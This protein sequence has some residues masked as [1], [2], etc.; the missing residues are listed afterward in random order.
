MARAFPTAASLRKKAAMTTLAY[1]VMGL[2]WLRG[3]DW[4]MESADLRGFERYSDLA[5]VALSG[6]VLYAA[7]SRPMA[8]RAAQPAK[9]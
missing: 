4:L 3:S 2:A 9:D 7:L 1:G 6:V 8:N 5:F